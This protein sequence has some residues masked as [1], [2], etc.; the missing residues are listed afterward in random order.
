[1]RKPDGKATG[2]VEIPRL[3]SGL[4]VADLS[5]AASP[6]RLAQGSFGDARKGSRHERGY[7]TAWDKQRLKILERDQY[8]CQCQTCKASGLVKAASEV[9]HVIPKE[10][11]GTDDESNLQAI[12]PRCHRAKTAAEQIRGGRLAR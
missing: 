6:G 1:M 9:D 2:R 8:L 7:G 11:G 10:L 5:I 4:Q 3:T 12:N